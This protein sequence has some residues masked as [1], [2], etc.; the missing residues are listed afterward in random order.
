MKRDKLNILRFECLAACM[1]VFLSAC[2]SAA[3]PIPYAGLSMVAPPEP[4][5]EQKVQVND[6][7]HE[8]WIRGHWAYDNGNFT[9]SPGYIAI[10]PNPTAVWSGDRWEQREY[11]WAYIPGCWR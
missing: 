7:V 2:S 9:W 1:I 5:E 4:P 3:P 10:R 6:P 11:G 8:L